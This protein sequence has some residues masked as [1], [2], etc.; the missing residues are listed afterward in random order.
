MTTYR[1]EIQEKIMQGKGITLVNLTPEF[2]YDERK[3]VKKRIERQLYD[4]FCKY[5]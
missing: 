1:T 5:V 3:E 2:S 4:V